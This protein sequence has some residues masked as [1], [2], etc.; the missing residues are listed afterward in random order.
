MNDI[1]FR[2]SAVGKL[3][4]EPKTLKE[5]P[6]SV[7]A[8]THIRQLVAQELFGVEFEVSSKQMEKGIIVEPE[9]IALLNRVR[10]LDLVKNTE[11]RTDDYFTGECDLHHAPARAGFDLK[12][13]WSA[14]TFP[15]AEVDC[16]DKLYE[17]QA[18]VYLHL[19]DADRWTVAYALVNTPENLIGF[20]PA[21]MHFFDHIP[22]HMRLT[23][24]T[25][26]RDRE[27][28]RAMV[29]KVEHARVYFREV[30]AEFERT[31]RILGADGIE[32]SL[33]RA[34]TIEC[35]PALAAN[36]PASIF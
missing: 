29:E 23:T 10:G 24:W 22:E 30:V 8:K 36:L 33:I 5:G 12:C 20:E 32:R 17:W 31:H 34:G 9:G 15:I 16:V 35:A 7:G 1:R 19:W 13:S 21:A 27:K 28:E 4:T 2:A 25:I 3:M 18:R 11:R 6:L 26:E 14:A